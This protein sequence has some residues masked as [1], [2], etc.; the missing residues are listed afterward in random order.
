MAPQ[1]DAAEVAAD[2][3]PDATRARPVEHPEAAA[4]GFR[5][6]YRE[7]VD[8]LL[9]A[10][11][12]FMLVGDTGM[13]VT[14]GRTAVAR[15][16]D[17]WELVPGPNDNNLIGT[18]TWTTW[19]A[20]RLF[21]TRPLAL[22]LVRMFDGLVFL[23]S[24]SGHPGLTARMVY[25]GWTR[26]V[27]GP[28][29]TVRRTRAGLEVQPPVPLDPAL[30]AELLA[31]F[32]PAGRW[33]YR[34]DPSE[35]FFSHYP[36]A[37]VTAYA[38][39][40]SFDAL[41]GYLRVSDCCTSLMRTPESYPWAG[42]FWGNHNSRDN[43]PDLGL[44]FVAALAA[45]QDSLAAPEVRA[46][47]ERAVAA[48][49]R[50]GD[51]MV[52]NDALM[53]VDEHHDYDTLVVSGQRRPDGETEIEDLG[54]LGDCGMAY[55][56]RAVSSGGLAMPVPEAPVPGSVERLLVGALG[57]LVDCPLPEGVRAC[58]ALDEAYC[59]K[60][61]AT[62]PAMEVAGQPWL[63]LVEEL[64][65]D[66]PGTAEQFIGSFQDDYYE[67][68]AAMLGLLE[69][70][71]ASGQPELA[72]SA[73]AALGDMTALMR[74]FAD[75]LWARTN[76]ERLAARRFE[77]AL[78]DGA[79]GLP[80]DAGDL[81]GLAREAARLQRIEALLDV[82][83]AVPAVLKSDEEL[84]AE[85]EARIAGKSETVKARYAA[86]YGDTPPVRRAGEGYEARGAPESAHPWQPVER[87]RHIDYGGFRLLE[88]LPLC[89]HS[90]ETV[91]CTWAALGCERVDLDG[92][93]AVGEADREAVSARL[94]ATGCGDQDDWC[95]G[96]DLD[97]TGAV[98]A[99]DAAF[100]EAAQGCWYAKP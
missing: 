63:D 25:P 46:A 96:A 34:E 49:R 70:A 59:G 18:S 38:I 40:Y 50:V 26:V 10:W 61:W 20:Y 44:G 39:T 42:G 48:G 41:P 65:V 69:Y 28:G 29:R 80:V 14:I 7:R 92:D 51:L 83:E 93:G 89:V 19:Y 27:D 100:A 23:E 79:G 76:P 37:D 72:A 45:S 12:R 21:R 17:D 64:D 6:Y 82:P 53:T 16:G 15:A 57:G 52:A 9:G 54:S 58:E 1:L 32:W 30:E 68:T 88:G 5:L 60:T 86:E 97:R 11:N 56:A 78:F 24:I 98:D 71:R 62:L 99:T 91:D 94:G 36:A 35:S 43:F 67:V 3:A 33:T 85:I 66:A 77:A 2:A 8:R 90:P 81:G 75:I 4:L 22:S 47:A 87:P 73:R 74:R 13:G 31:T 84:R 55:L 95:D